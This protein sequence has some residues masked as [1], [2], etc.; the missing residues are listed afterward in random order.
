LLSW[1]DFLTGKI[2]EFKAIFEAFDTLL[3]ELIEEHKKV[4]SEAD[5]CSTEKG[6]VDILIQHQKNAMPDSELTNNDIKSILLVF[7]LFYSI[8]FFLLFF[9]NT[10]YPK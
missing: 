4:Q 8:A 9:S 6:F 3:D 5:H 1:V 10:Y 2:Q 7:L